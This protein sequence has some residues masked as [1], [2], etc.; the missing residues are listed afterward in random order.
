MAEAAFDYRDFDEEETIEIPDGGIADF[1]TAETGSWSDKAW[2]APAL[3]IGNISRTAD[4]LAEF[5]RFE[6][7]YLAHVAPNET[8]VPAEVLD[9]NPHLKAALFGQMRAAGLDP[10]RYVVGNEANSINPITGQPEFWNIGRALKKGLRKVFKVVKRVV[11]K[12]L[13]I[14][15]SMTTLGPIFGSMVGSGIGTLMEGGDFNDALKAA[16]ISGGTAGILRGLQGGLE[17]M[18]EGGSGFVAGAQEAVGQ[19]LANPGARFAQALGGA[20][21]EGTSY[22]GSP[23]RDVEPVTS[24]VTDAV[25]PLTSEVTDAVRQGAA[26]ERGRALASMR[27]TDPGVVPVEGDAARRG[28]AI[29]REEAGQLGTGTTGPK[30]IET[31]GGDFKYTIGDV[32]SAAE[33]F[34]PPGFFES[35]GQAFTPGDDV[36]FLKGMGQAFY[37]QGA[38]PAQIIKE[39]FPENTVLTPEHW[40]FAKNVSQAKG[41]TP[42]IVRRWGPI[43]GVTML[44]SAMQPKPEGVEVPDEFKQTGFDLLAGPGGDQYMLPIQELPPITMQ[45]LANTGIGPSTDIQYRMGA[46][47]ARGGDVDAYPP[48]IGAISGPGTERSDDVPAMLSDGEFVFTAKAVRGAGGGSRENG[49]QNLYNLMRNF[50]GRV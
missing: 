1:L 2:D 15:L 4:Q 35:I 21:P 28:A 27:Q 6:D 33:Q 18:Q 17:G 44:A 36:G 50:E 40:E 41:V 22:F 48:R 32:K 24:G 39:F 31:V 12:I 3:G 49:N 43:F 8:I 9:E 5:G 19:S 25:E 20:R 7:E 45:Q 37:P 26:Q 10:S 38:T 11:P 34:K 42:N 29:A 16:A 14:V 23:L 13:P 30:G 46:T 47:A